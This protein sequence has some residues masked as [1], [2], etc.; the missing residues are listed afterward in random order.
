MHLYAQQRANRIAQSS[1]I[2][3]EPTPELRQI[4]FC[5]GPWNVD[6]RTPPG[7]EGSNGSLLCV[8]RGHPGT[9]NFTRPAGVQRRVGRGSPAPKTRL[10]MVARLGSHRVR[11]VRSA[12]CPCRIK[13]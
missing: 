2:F 6:L 10:V 7:P 8:C 1:P 5:Q 3:L 13:L 4:L 12:F 9:L 11:S